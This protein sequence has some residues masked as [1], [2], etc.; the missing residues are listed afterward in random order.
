MA[1]CWDETVGAAPGEVTP[2]AVPPVCCISG[3]D[4]VLLRPVLSSH[5]APEAAGGWGAAS[6]NPSLRGDSGVT[7]ATENTPIA[8]PS[9]GPPAREQ[10]PSRNV[11]SPF[12]AT[13]SFVSFT[14]LFGVGSSHSRKG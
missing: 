1:K 10:Y 11:F 14:L 2:V 3:M 7:A 13:F 4:P 12:K 9:N 5:C 8:L 6:A